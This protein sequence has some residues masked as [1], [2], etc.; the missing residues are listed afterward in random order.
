MSNQF[1]EY[2]VPLLRT[3]F[4]E[5]AGLFTSLIHPECPA[6]WLVGQAAPD[7][8][9]LLQKEA[10][11]CAIGR[12]AGRLHETLPFEQWASQTLVTE[13]QSTDSKSV[14]CHFL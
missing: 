5:L 13:A 10:L 4:N 12:C 2:V 7:F 3:M 11:Y 6:H 1:P 14:R 9:T 8:Q